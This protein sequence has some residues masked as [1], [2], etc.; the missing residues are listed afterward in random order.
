MTDTHMPRDKGLDHT[1]QLLHEGYHYVM[2]R[3][4]KFD[5][6]LFE[7][8][9]LGEKVICM[10]GQEEAALFYDNAKFSRKDAS[11]SRIQKTLFGEGGVQ[12]LDGQEHHHR[13]EMFMSLMSQDGLARMA[14]FIQEEWEQEM[15]QYQDEKVIIYSLAKR[16]LT[17]A[18]LRWTGVPYQEDQIET[19]SDHLGDMFEDAGAV[20][21]KHWQAR[22]SRN[23]AEDWIKELVG[24]VREKE[25]EVGEDSPLYHFVW[26]RDWNGELLDKSIVAV[27]LLNLL[28]PIVAIAVYIDFL[29]LAIHDYPEAVRQL[30]TEQERE[31]F[32][33]EVR[34]FYPFFPVAPARVKMDFEW[35]GYRFTKGTLVLLD[36][37]GTNHD[38]AIWD[39][40]DT[41]QPERFKEWSGSPFD[42]IPQGGGE[43]DIG[44][45]CAGEWLTLEVLKVTL[46]FFVNQITYI[47]PEQDLTY[48]MN[49]IPPLPKSRV[50]M[51][52]VHMK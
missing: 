13:K 18:A 38:P 2:N 47:F 37:Y 23:K 10:V 19:W 3:S 1:L 9:L 12:G 25:I 31:H 20:G 36:L 45:R 50:V 43:F 41:F 46:D 11:P 14:S 27:E 16:V 24:K 39:H 8:K 52:Q 40:P 5:S 7:T 29:A 34:R 44:H 32:I 21:L 51:E 35:E 15:D 33:Q 22:R 28:R 30:E 17:R 48:K 26:H 42:F 49:D 6:R 4:D